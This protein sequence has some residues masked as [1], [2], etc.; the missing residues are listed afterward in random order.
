MTCQWELE[1]V[2]DVEERRTEEA[3]RVELDFTVR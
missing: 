1:M 3:N 2:G